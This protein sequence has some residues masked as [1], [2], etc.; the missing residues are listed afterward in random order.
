MIALIFIHCAIGLIA[1]IDI[2]TLRFEDW[3]FM[4]LY[5]EVILVTET[6]LTT[7]QASYFILFLSGHHVTDRAIVIPLLVPF[8][9]TICCLLWPFVD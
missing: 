7:A 6:V 2:L 8:W 4:C 9:S 3:L 1:I 5:K